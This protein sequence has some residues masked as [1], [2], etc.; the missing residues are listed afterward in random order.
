M[1]PGDQDISVIDNYLLKKNI[2]ESIRSAPGDSTTQ[3]HRLQPFLDEMKKE[4]CKII[5]H[6]L[7]Q[8]DFT[9][10]NAPKYWDALVLHADKMQTRLNRKV[11]L[12]TVACDYFSTVRPYLNNP[13]LI[14]FSS[15]E[16]TLKSAHHDFL[17]GLLSRGSFQNS[18]EQEISRA[19]R[20]G[21]N[22]TLIFF[23]LDNFKAINDKHGHIA[24]DA[25]LKEVGKIL[26][27]SKR[28]EDI[29]CRF[30]GDEFVILLPET[31]KFMGSLVGKKLLEQINT[32]VIHH[33]GKQVPV[34]CS[35]GL[36]SFPLDSHNDQELISCADRAMYQ[37]KSRGSHELTLFSAEKRIFTRIDFEDTISIRSLEMKRIDKE[38][39]AKNISEGGI[40]VSSTTKYDLG[41]QLELYIPL[42]TDT[43]LTITGT[44]VRL[45]QFGTDC[46]DIGLSFLHRD[47][48]A[49]STQAI[50]DYIV[51]QLARELP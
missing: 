22:I 51:Q 31:N 11:G 12:A 43:N 14:E 27:D 17:T 3:C 48:S 20:H 33:E 21:H 44:V 18:L 46:Y 5:L 40:L 38:S 7:V 16:E 24:G 39:K 36:A 25:A 42:K 19:K 37:A 28:K 10:D 8:L 13:K 23:D 9:L 15:F 26:L 32:I 41:T 29:A 35:A 47:T 30:G 34:A 1:T 50:A 2:L 49:I 4:T 45:E 6:N